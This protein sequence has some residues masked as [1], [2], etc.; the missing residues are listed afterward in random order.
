[1]GIWQDLKEFDKKLS[2]KLRIN[3]YFPNYINKWVFRVYFVIIALVLSAIIYQNGGLTSSF[4]LECPQDAVK[5]INPFYKCRPG[6]DK[7][8]E[9][10]YDPYNPKGDGFYCFEDTRQEYCDKGLCEKE[11]LLGG[12]YIGNKPSP[13]YEWF[14]FILLG[15]LILAFMLNHLIYKKGWRR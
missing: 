6:R 4:Y 2:E 10:F 15:G 5:C 14:Y 3:N 8:N 11:Y 9:G 12:E 7:S 13:L 1:M